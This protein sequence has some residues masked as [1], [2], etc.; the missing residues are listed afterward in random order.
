MVTLQGKRQ[1]NYRTDIDIIVVLLRDNY[2]KV[3][4]QRIQKTRDRAS[5]YSMLK[6]RSKTQYLQWVKSTEKFLGG[7]LFIKAIR[8][9]C[10]ALQG[11]SHQG[12]RG[13]MAP[14]LLQFPN[15][16]RSN[17]FS[18]KHQGYCFLRLFRDCMDQKFLDFYRVCCKSWTIYGSFSFFLT[19]Q[20][21][22]ITSRWT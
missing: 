10:V 11:R 1:P 21:K 9:L 19:T 7:V 13:S 4:N 16:K 5:I 18:F 17:S 14:P 3:D 12:A 2:L 6:W 15:Q 20:E 8:K 22:Q